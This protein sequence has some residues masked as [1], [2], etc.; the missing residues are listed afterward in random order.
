MI[1]L[2]IIHILRNNWSNKTLKYTLKYKN[3]KNR[4]P[5]KKTASC[6]NYSKKLRLLPTTAQKEVIRNKGKA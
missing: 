6:K 2:L 3:M 4:V 5:D 1:P